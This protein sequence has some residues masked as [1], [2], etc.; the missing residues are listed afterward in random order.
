[1][2]DTTTIR[3]SREIYNMVKDL[4]KQQDENIQDVIQHAV[5]EYKKKRFF[6][7]LNDAYAKLKSDPKAWNEELEEREEWDGVLADGLESK[8]EDQ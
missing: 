6:D 4:A 1:M 5:T 2:G 7:N 8:D 3:V